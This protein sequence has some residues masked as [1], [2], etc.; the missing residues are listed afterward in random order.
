[1][2]AID[3]AITELTTQ[4]QSNTDAENSAVT[5]IQ[6]LAALIQSNANDPAAIRSLAAKLKTSAD[7]LGA[8]VTANTPASG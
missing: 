3:D 6:Q 4:V 7:A 8:A 2:S 5:L 1:M